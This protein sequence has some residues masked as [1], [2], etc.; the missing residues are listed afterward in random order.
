MELEF[1]NWIGEIPVG[2]SLVFV[3][4]IGVDVRG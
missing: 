4:G 1:W 2:E 3:F